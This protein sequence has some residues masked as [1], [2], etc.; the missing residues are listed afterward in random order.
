[1]SDRVMK[2]NYCYLMVPNR[3]GQGAKVFTAIR[4]GGVNLLAH[5]GFPGKK[6]SAQLDFVAP[7]L[8]KIRGV[9]RR[10]GWRV[11]RPKKAFLVQ[12]SDK[13]GAVNRH[14]ARLADARV[15]VTAAAALA[16]GGNRYGMIVWVKPKDYARAARALKA[17]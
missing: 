3:P 7:N 8:S 2:V 14:F 12:G 5:V 15:G 1:M 13:S 6:G 9:A 10:N 11:S 17:R 4:Q 16:A